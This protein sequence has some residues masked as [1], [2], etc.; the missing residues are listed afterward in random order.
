LAPGIQRQEEDGKAPVGEAPRD[1]APGSEE[2]VAL[3]TPKAAQTGQVTIKQPQIDEYEV[4]GKT[5]AEVIGQLDPE[6][7][8]HCSWTV[9]YNY[10]TANGKTTKVNIT[11]HLIIRMP[12][13]GEG[14]N[15]A[16]PAARKEWQRML[17]VL[18]KHED[19]HAD[20]AR[21]WAP[22]FKGRLLSQPEEKADSIYKQ[23]L[24]ELDDE[25]KKYDADTKH[26]QAQGVSLDTSI[27]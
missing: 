25:S 4:T 17:T 18:R 14:Y 21:K 22:I 24:Q 15:D 26:G 9:D 12:R 1:K 10:D 16:S 23:A 27:Q 7:W 13:W 2:I 5:L 8:G 20:I 19:G 6:E 11:L 3:A